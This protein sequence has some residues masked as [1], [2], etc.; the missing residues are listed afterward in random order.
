MED[1]TGGR[2]PQGGSGESASKAERRASVEEQLAET[3]GTRPG[4]AS[5]ADEQPVHPDDVTDAEPETPLGVG[6][7]TTRRGED[8][9]DDD[10]KEPGRHDAGTQGESDRPVGVSD[11]RDS[12]GVDPQSSPDA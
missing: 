2:D 10:G 6:T 3:K 1:S 12:T 7:S 4:G 11:E 9:A 5:P 8:L